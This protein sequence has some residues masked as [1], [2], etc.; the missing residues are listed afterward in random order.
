[1]SRAVE[2]RG[3][4]K[5]LNLNEGAFIYIRVRKVNNFHFFGK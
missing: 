4:K 3:F 5:K 1:V 2:M